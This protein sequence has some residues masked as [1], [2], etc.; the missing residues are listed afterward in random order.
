M[1]EKERPKHQPP[2]S[3]RDF[4]PRQSFSTRQLPGGSPVFDKVFP[5][6]LGF[7]IGCAFGLWLA[8]GNPERMAFSVGGIGHPL[9]NGFIFGVV[10]GTLTSPLALWIRKGKDS[11]GILSTTILLGLVLGFVLPMLG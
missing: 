11:G 7:G 6:A 2:P 4:N 8:V 1:V 9:F 5:C 3:P 10:F